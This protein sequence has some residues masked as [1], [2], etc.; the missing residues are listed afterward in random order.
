MTTQEIREILNQRQQ[1]HGDF[2]EVAMVAQ[3]LKS[4]IKHGASPALRA[5]HTEALDMIASK[6]ARI[7]RG[8]ADNLDSW[9]DIAGYATL[10]VNEI[11]KTKGVK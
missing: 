6:V 8:D 10:V 5:I 11:R 2:D 3:S 9:L 1:T 4:A 7:C